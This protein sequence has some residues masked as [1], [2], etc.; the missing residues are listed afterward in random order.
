MASF[1]EQHLSDQSEACHWLMAVGVLL[2]A[3]ISTRTL[4]ASVK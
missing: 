3:R 2:C 1:E 4:T